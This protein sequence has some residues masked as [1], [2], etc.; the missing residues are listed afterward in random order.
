M[1]I[2][3]SVP[4]APLTTFRVG[5]PADFFITV[6]TIDE[7][8]EA[9]RFAREGKLPF[10][11]LGGGSNVL[12]PDDG[13]RGVIVK[14][15]ITGTEYED[16]EEDVLVT[17]GSGE[18][19]DTFVKDTV[20]RG[21]IGL[22][23]LS[24]IPGTVGATP[25]QNVGAY[26]AEVEGLIEWVEVFDRTTDPVRTL[27]RAECAFGYRD[28]IFKR[29]EGKSLLITR[30]CYRLHKHAP[31]ITTYKDVALLL[32]ERGIIQPTLEDMRALVLEIRMSKS[33][34]LS[35]LGSAGSFFKNPVITKEAYAEVLKTFPELPKYPVDDAHV[36]IPIAHII[37]KLGLRGKRVGNVG[38]YAKSALKLVNYGGGTAAEISAFADSVQDAVREK[39][40]I[41]IEREVQLLS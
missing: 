13:F 39:T 15:E 16:A 34:N 19:W 36:K 14:N 21:L 5:G 9:S 28:S 31:F 30:V 25:V 38:F 8:R 32:T 24:G 33:P 26:G 23:N 2:K 1:E 3:E 17:A 35:E 29:P 18:D 40:G 20:D 10:A 22:E 4:L 12:V 6:R 11:I 37:E 27:T 7:L 41:E